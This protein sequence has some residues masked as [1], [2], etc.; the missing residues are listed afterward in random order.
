M[1]DCASN[2]GKAVYQAK[3]EAKRLKDE[4]RRKL[5][6]SAA[7]DADGQVAAIDGVRY[8]GK[9]VVSF[10]DTPAATAAGARTT[11]RWTPRTMRK[12]R[13]CQSC[14]VVVCLSWKWCDDDD[15]PFIVLNHFGN[16][17]RHFGHP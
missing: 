7:A 4:E 2:T 15:D 6:Q 3:K 10:A 1:L 16:L 13:R 14:R 12:K 17:A 8:E 9:F 11:S 5:E